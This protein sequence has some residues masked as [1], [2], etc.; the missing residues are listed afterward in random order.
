MFGGWVASNQKHHNS[1]HSKTLQNQNDHKKLTKN[2]MKTLLI[3]MNSFY[4][5]PIL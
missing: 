2:I 4:S 1:K 5:A 3:G